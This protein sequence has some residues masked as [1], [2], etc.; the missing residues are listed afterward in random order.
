MGM[1][2]YAKPVDCTCTHNF[3]CGVCLRNAKP[4]HWTP[5]PESYWAAVDAALDAEAEGEAQYVHDPDDLHRPGHDTHTNDA[6]GGY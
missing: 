2:G 3:T 5:S 1:R 4:W 6:R